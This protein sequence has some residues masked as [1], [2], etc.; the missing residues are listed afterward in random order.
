[1]EKLSRKGLAR[2]LV[3]TIN[4][5]CIGVNHSVADAPVIEPAT[6]QEIIYNSSCMVVVS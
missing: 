2:I 4:M 1:M 3:G 6:P 5:C